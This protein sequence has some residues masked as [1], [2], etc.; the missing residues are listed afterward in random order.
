MKIVNLTP[1]GLNIETCRGSG[2]GVMT[3]PP[4]GDV[5]RVASRTVA[6]PRRICGVVVYETV[7]GEVEG[8]PGPRDGVVYVVSGMVAAAGPRPD[9]FSPGDLLRDAFGSPVGC[10]G[11][12]ASRAPEQRDCPNCGGGAS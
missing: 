1:H 5:A 8:L 4:S 3:V 9:V 10:R 6:T 12:R 7:L 11:L 2:R